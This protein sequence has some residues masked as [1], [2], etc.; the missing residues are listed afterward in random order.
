MSKWYRYST[1]KRFLS[2]SYP[3]LTIC[4]PVNIT[5]IVL[6]AQTNHISIYGMVTWAVMKA[7]N[8]IDAFRLR[9]QGDKLALYNSVGV[10]FSALKP[11]NSYCYTSIVEF[12][13]MLPFLNEFQKAKKVAE[14]DL[15]INYEDRDDVI[16]ITCVPMARITSVVNP[17][18]LDIQDCIPRICWGKYEAQGDQFLI[19]VSVQ[20]HHSLADGLH[21]GALFQ[22]LHEISEEIVK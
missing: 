11:D 6:Y 8:S 10:S 21:I 13:E 15:I 16:Y 1:Y 22:N 7:V 9:I 2:Y 3:Y 18:R 14:S 5:Q 12:D 4:S 20:V 19:D 17:M